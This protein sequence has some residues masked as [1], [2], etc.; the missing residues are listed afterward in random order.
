MIA[1]G[2]CDTEV[3]LLQMAGLGIAVGNATEAAKKAA[4]FIAEPA[5]QDGVEKAFVKLGMIEL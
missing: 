3:E 4:D 2:A 5:A 1:V